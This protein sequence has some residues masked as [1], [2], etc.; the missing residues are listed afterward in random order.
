VASLVLELEAVQVRSDELTNR[1]GIVLGHGRL[2]PV[3]Q[4]LDALESNKQHVESVLIVNHNTYGRSGQADVK[5]PLFLLIS[6]RIEVHTLVIHFVSH[7]TGTVDL[8][9]N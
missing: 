9:V 7:V 4:E 6:E 2:D 8:L 5:R 1:F 3:L